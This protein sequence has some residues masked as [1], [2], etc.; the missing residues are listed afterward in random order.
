MDIENEWLRIECLLSDGSDNED[1][2]N[3]AK[4][5][6]DSLSSPSVLPPGIFITGSLNVSGQHA[7]NPEKCHYLIR[8]Y[9]PSRKSFF[10]PS[11]LY[12]N[13]DWV[14]WL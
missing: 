5:I 14:L 1:F 8:I 13:R 9:M 2:R 6:G 12:Y 11:L 7:A 3:V 10:M 4:E